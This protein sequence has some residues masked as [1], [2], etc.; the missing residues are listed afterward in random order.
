MAFGCEV[1][2]KSLVLLSGGYSDAANPPQSIEPDEIFNVTHDELSQVEDSLKST[3]SILLHMADSLDRFQHSLIRM[4]DTVFAFGGITSSSTTTEK[5]KVF[6]EAT[7][8]WENHNKSLRSKETG[9]V[10]VLPFP[11]FSLDCV[12]E[13]QCGVASNVTSRIFNGTN[14]QAKFS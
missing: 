1:L 6:N 5:I 10:V 12:P 4:K 14:A 2:N 7:L 9:E 13:C 11:T 8:T 3:G